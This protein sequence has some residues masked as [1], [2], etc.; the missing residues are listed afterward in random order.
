MTFK[1][2]EEGKT[3]FAEYEVTCRY[4]GWVNAIGTD[5]LPAKCI[6]R[7]KCFATFEIETSIGTLTKKGKILQL[8]GSEMVYLTNNGRVKDLAIFSEQE[9]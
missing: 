5:T 3:Y 9:A 6:R 7:T 2:F 8:D 1:A 4:K